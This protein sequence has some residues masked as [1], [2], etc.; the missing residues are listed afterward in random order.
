MREF[1]LL[2]PQQ[3]VSALEVMANKA[4]KKWAISEPVLWL[5]KYRE[6]C[7]FGVKDGISGDKYALRIHRP[8][9]HSNAALNSELRWM[10]AL[11]NDGVHTPEIIRS[12]N[13]LLMEEI[14][15][16]E[17]PEARVCDLLGWVIGEVLGTIDGED[18]VGNKKS[19]REVEYDHFFAGQ[20][21]AKIH[22]QAQ[23]WLLPEG[24]SRPIMDGPGLVSEQGY[25]GDFR[26]HPNLTVAQ[27]LLLKKA[28]NLV[29][30]DLESFGKTADRFG[31][32][33]A[34]FLPENLLIDGE[35]IRII[36]FDDCG[37][38]WYMMDI[39]TALF[40]LQGQASYDSAYKGLTRGYRSCRDL[41]KDHLAMLPAFFLARGLAYLGWVGTRK[42]TQEFIELSPQLIEGAVAMAEEYLK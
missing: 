8:G 35:D 21:A 28:A 30:R 32:T 31:L 41:P 27:L 9:Y 7:V 24:F 16:D 10:E 3:Q 6:N 22:N 4:V 18:E 38:G 40:F 14:T 20:I 37:F 34:D 11:H 2:A 36:D 5:L 13:N 39:A 19:F 15:V 25:L 1:Y 42:E 26:T 17:V 33:H 29:S 12:R 23:K